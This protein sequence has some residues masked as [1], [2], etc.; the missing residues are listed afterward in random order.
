MPESGPRER[1]FE[2]VVFDWDGT[3][4][5]SLGFI[6]RSV[7]YAIE[8]LGLEAR[9][10]SEIKAIIGLGLEQAMSTL[11]P[12]ITAGKRDCLVTHYREHYLSI[13]AGRIQLYPNIE[14][15]L[16][17]RLDNDYTSAVATAIV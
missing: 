6:V 15:T 11:Y 10:V 12:G 13:S 16:Q 8:Q 17:S 4:S 5:D 1:A 7:Q 9:T 2:L 14:R 3:I